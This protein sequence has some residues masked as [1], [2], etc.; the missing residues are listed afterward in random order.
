VIGEVIQSILD[1]GFSIRYEYKMTGIHEVH[2]FKIEK[3]SKEKRFQS[4]WVI[5]DSIVKDP[6]MAST[7]FGMAEHHMK[8]IDDALRPYRLIEEALSE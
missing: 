7:I 1:K 4:S 6:R 5:A 2:V 8:L 3:W